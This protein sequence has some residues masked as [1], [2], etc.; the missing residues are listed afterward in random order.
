MTRHAAGRDRHD[1]VLPD[2]ERVAGVLD[3]GGDI[4]AE[5]VLALAQADHQGG[6]AAGADDESRVVLVHREQGEGALEAADDGAECGLEVAVGGLVFAAEQDR[7]GLGVGL[8]AERVALRQQVGLDVGEVLDDAVVDDREL[9]VVGEVRVRVRVGRTAVG[10]P[11]RVA[12]SGRA[13][14]ERVRDQVVAQHLE[15]AGALAHAQLAPAVDDGDT[16]GVVAPVLEPSEP[17][18]KN[19]LAVARAHVSDDS[20]HGPNPTGDGCVHPERGTLGQGAMNTGS[21]VPRSQGTGML[22]R[23][24]NGMPRSPL[25]HP[26]PGLREAQLSTV[27]SRG[28]IRA[29]E[30]VGLLRQETGFCREGRR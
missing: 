28:A 2:R 9:V 30:A 7:G 16:G 13:V 26:V 25:Q 27:P 8:A 21:R 11:A 22:E 1:L 17:C 14:G 3:E 24:R 23:S 10:R 4:R 15:L 12:D 29:D 19:G 5:E 6:V 18:E 20:T